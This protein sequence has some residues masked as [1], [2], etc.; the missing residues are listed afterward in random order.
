MGTAVPANALSGRLACR[1]AGLIY[2]EGLKDERPR[3]LCF[4]PFRK[5]NRIFPC[6]I[7]IEFA[8]ACVGIAAI[9]GLGDESLRYVARDTQLALCGLIHTYTLRN[10]FYSLHDF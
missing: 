1:A 2:S 8:F 9:T 4:H 10:F 6:R 7:W 3:H 5:P